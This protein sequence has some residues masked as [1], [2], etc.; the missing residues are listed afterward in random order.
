MVGLMVGS[1]SHCAGKHDWTLDSKTLLKLVQTLWCGAMKLQ[2]SWFSRRRWVLASCADARNFVC[3]G[4]SANARHM[5]SYSNLNRR[6][7]EST[8]HFDRSFAF[9]CHIRN[10]AMLTVKFERKVVNSCFLNEFSTVFNQTSS[11][12]KRNV[13]RNALAQTPGSPRVIWLR[14]NE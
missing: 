1:P 10:W 5:P 9:K 7:S 6:I 4:V 12:V 14:K 3:C 13:K 8:F 2:Q 11:S